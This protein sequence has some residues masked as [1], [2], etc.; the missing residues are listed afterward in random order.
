MQ[1]SRVCG[2]LGHKQ[3]ICSTPP[4][5]RPKEHFR[6]GGTNTGEDRDKTGQLHSWPRLQ[7]WWPEQEQVSQHSGMDKGG[8]WH[9]HGSEASGPVHGCAHVND[10]R[11]SG[12]HPLPTSGL[13]P[14][15]AL[16]YRFLWRITF[17]LTLNLCILNLTHPSGS[18]L[19]FRMQ[20]SNP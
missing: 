20:F 9:S 12:L 11:H 5:P 4:P 1:R 15:P 7:L 13:A 8:P 10:T 17:L 6:R 2:E 3:D 16:C 18:Y 14:S 19:S